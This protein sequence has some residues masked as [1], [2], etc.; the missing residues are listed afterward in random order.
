MKT[1]QIIYL[2]IALI[3]SSMMNAQRFSETLS[4]TMNFPGNSTDNL[5]VVYNIDGSIE[6]E[7][8]NGS[9]V[10]ITVDKEIKGNNQRQL[11]QG[12]SEVSMKTASNGNIIYVYL[13]S[14]YSEFNVET[15]RFNHR[16]SWNGTTYSHTLNYKIRVPKNTNVELSTVN[17]GNIN[18]KNIDAQDITVKN[19]NGGIKLENV[20]GKTYV[21]ALNKNIS[22]SHSKVPT[23][24][25]V[26]KSLNGDIDITVPSGL[27]ADVSFKSLNGDIYT[28]LE[29][30]SSSK[31]SSKVSKKGNKRGTRYKLDKRTQFQIGNGG[32]RMDFDLLNGDVTI[33]G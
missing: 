27:N 25:S 1:K 20:A 6:V 14:P 30:K 32:V 13:D 2:C 8:Y 22:I 17:R 3:S 33:K 28:N 29:T 9:T 19:I 24:D 12:K 31:T 16:G 10:E 15:G 4:E 21:D 7:G 11:E 18:V 26:Y 23:A 5:L